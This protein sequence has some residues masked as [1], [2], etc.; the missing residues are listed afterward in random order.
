MKTLLK[1]DLKY[2]FLLFSDI[3]ECQDP[4]IAARC[5]ENAECCNLPAHF[6]CKC[7]DGYEGDGELQCTDIDE[8]LNPKACGLNAHCINTPGNYTCECPEGFYGNAYDGCHDIDECSHPEVCGPGAIC[9][10]LEGSYRCDCPQGYEGDGRSAEGCVDHDECARSPCGRN[11]EC[12]NTDGSFKC[13]CPDGYAGDPGQGC[14]GK[15]LLRKSS[16]SW[17]LI[18]KDFTFSYFIKS[19]IICA[20]K[21]KKYF[22]TLPNSNTFMH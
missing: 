14:E 2:F 17:R 8:C 22:Y 11:A 20:L 1:I 10:N 16:L 6:L 5:V 7:K 21:Q 3:D 4:S 15:W 9:T 13:L 19:N 12:L 18:F